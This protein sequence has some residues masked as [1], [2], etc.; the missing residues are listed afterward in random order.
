MIDSLEGP[1]RI[2]LHSPPEFSEFMGSFA[3]LFYRLE[4]R[5]AMS[6]YVLG[7]LAPIKR[8]NCEGLA[9][10]LEGI[11]A[12]RLQALLTDIPWDYTRMDRL[13]VGLLLA[14]ARV[15]DGVLILDDT[16]IPKQGKAS[17]GVARQYSGT[18]GK[19]G[20]CQ[21]TVTCRYADP[22]YTWPVAGRL[23]LPG[24]WASDQERRAKAKVP[25][26]VKFQTKVEIALALLDQ[27]R[28]W[29]IGHEAVTADCNYGDN[30]NFLAGLESRHEP[31]VVAVAKDFTVR[32]P[33]ELAK[34][35]EEAALAGQVGPSLAAGSSESAVGE[36]TPGG[37]ARGQAPGVDPGTG[38]KPKRRGRPT[39]PPRVLAPEERAPLHKACQLTG[40][41]PEQSWQAITY[42]VGTAGPITKE[43]LALRACRAL[44]GNA[45][46][47]G[48]FTGGE[49]WLI[50]ERPLVGHEGDLKWYYSN[51]P[52]EARLGRMVEIGHRRE[53]IERGY[54]VGKDGLGLDEAEVRLWHGFHRHQ[55]LVMLAE[56][57]LVLQRR[58]HEPATG[59]LPE[60]E[61]ALAG[62]PV[63]PAEAAAGPSEPSASTPLRTPATSTTRPM[64][65]PPDGVDWR[66]L[67]SR[68]SADERVVLHHPRPLAGRHQP[69][70]ASACPAA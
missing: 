1:V 3:N 58:W 33:S 9:A 40:S 52:P 31:Y 22:S 38:G 65:S 48:A 66:D 55:A 69:D 12:E 29:G 21:I 36:P 20:N 8:K 34:A 57:W 24:S 43:F 56:S 70:H 45:A 44:K 63:E 61:S 41:Q 47:E 37:S 23:Y 54:R 49:G 60:S 17:V 15:G 39:K 68:A 18:L 46:G 11:T 42:R 53:P 35:R 62:P 16:G 26:E 27:A 59:P 50:G 7:L 32:L 10:A 67:T 14:R 13:R 5:W 19:V 6:R 30:P 4:G 64:P 2:G 51:F 25:A 28:A